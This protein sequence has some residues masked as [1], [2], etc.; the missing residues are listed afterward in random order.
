MNRSNAQDMT[1]GPL[2]RQILLFSL[3]LIATNL[4]QVLFNLADVAVVGQFAGTLA[5]GSVGS[6]T[7]LVS[8]FTGVLIGIG[9]GINVLTARYAGARDADGEA[10][11]VH[12][13]LLLSLLIG[14]ALTA[15]GEWSL[16]GVLTLLGTRED[17]MDG[18]VLYMRIYLLGVPALALYNFG[19]AVHAAVGDTRHPLLYLSLAGALNIALN[20][21]FVIALRLSVAGVALASVL[22]QLLSAVLILRSLARRADAAG[23]RLSRLRLHKKR[24]REVLALGIPSGVQNA[25]FACANLVTM[26]GVN[27]F[28]TVMVSG[29]A[30][31]ANADNLVYDVMIAFYTACGSFMGQNYGARKPERVRRSYRVSVAWAF[32]AAAVMGGLL[33]LFGEGFLALFTNDPLVIGAGMKRLRIMA[34]SYCLSA[35]MDCSI[36]ASRALGSTLVPTVLVLLGSCVFRVT[37]VFTVFAYFRTIPSLYLLY[38]CSFT[39][40]GV[41]ET[42]YYL[43]VA[44]KKLNRLAD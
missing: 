28:S 33:V 13:A 35:F 40:T 26:S 11:T 43:R 21:F 5:L 22:S 16:R 29:N 42:A 14:L 32:G 27:T 12:T 2:G 17:L 38:A 44:R 15:A 3:P 10:E 4:L 37:W 6:D 34:P 1:V 7:T 9:G 30:A 18:A 41:M 8:L 31:A 24:A 20:L 23:L 36:A 19:S 25:I 39:L